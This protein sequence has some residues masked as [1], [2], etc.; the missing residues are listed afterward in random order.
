MGEPVTITSVRKAEHQRSHPVNTGTSEFEQLK[1]DHLYLAG[2]AIIFPLF[3]EKTRNLTM[4][5]M[6]QVLLVYA[7]S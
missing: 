1:V 3:Q 5:I 4:Q 2:N 6:F 7:L